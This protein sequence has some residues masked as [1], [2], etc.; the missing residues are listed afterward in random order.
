[1]K[2]LTG[3]EVWHLIA[4]IIPVGTDTWK[5]VY[6]TVFGALK[7]HDKWEKGELVEKKG[8]K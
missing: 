8:K 1:M 3:M 5:E 6:V 2:E 4:P 7:L